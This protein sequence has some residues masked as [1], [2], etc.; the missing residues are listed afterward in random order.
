VNIFFERCV[1]LYE[2]LVPIAEAHDIRLILHPSDPPLADA[3]FSPRR[4]SRI[5]DAVPSSHS[6]L[7]YCVG[8][9]YASGVDIEADIRAFGRRGK[10]FHVHFRNVRGTLLTDSAHEE[11][12][13][14]DGDMNMSVCYGL[15]RVSGIP[16]VS[17][18]TICHGTVATTASRAA[19]P[20]T[21]SAIS[22]PCWRPWRLRRPGRDR[23]LA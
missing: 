19:R 2:R 4:W 16:E 10:I 22:G 18:S 5:L 7:L 1:R 13:L 11:V 6:G 9:R 8:T 21:P 20:P 23:H 17:R 3:P 12:A 14:H 15:S